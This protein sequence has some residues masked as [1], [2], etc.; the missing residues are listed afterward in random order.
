MDMTISPTGSPTGDAALGFLIVSIAT[1]LMAGASLVAARRWPSW[2]GV[3][4]PMAAQG[5]G[6]GVAAAVLGLIAALS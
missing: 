5:A 2:L 3:A 4:G 6:F 1:C